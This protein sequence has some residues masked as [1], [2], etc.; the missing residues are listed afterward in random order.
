MEGGRKVLREE[1]IAQLRDKATKRIRDSTEQEVLEEFLSC[2]RTL[3]QSV[4]VIGSRETTTVAIVAT[5]AGEGVAR[6]DPFI[7]YPIRVVDNFGEVKFLDVVSHHADIRAL[8]YETLSGNNPLARLAQDLGLKTLWDIS[9]MIPSP[10]VPKEQRSPSWVKVY[11]DLVEWASLYEFVISATASSF[12]HALILRD[13]FLRS[14]IFRPG[15]FESMWERIRE[16]VSAAE[17]KKR[18]VYIV[19]VAKKSKVL[20]RYRLAFHLEG[21]FDSPD[22]LYLPVPPEVERQVYR[23]GEYAQGNEGGSWEHFSQGRLYFA[24]FGEGPYAPVWP[25]DVWSDQEH[26]VDQIMGYL[27]ANARAGFPIKDYPLALQQAHRWASMSDFDRE[28]TEGV[29]YEAL[30]AAL[31][32]SG[33]LDELLL[34]QTRGR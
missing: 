25:I 2:A 9:P 12:S 6:F 22:P 20:D 21:V 1:E 29:L 28:V 14:K 17:S 34:L 3:K 11:R 26:E 27:L 24:K 33:D 19:G 15:L 10:E 32:K 7:L 18:K 16:A 4:R 23:W 13:G 30:R 5:D 31:E 8:S